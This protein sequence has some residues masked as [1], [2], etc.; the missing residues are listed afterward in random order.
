MAL[1]TLKYDENGMPKRAKYRIVVLGNLA[2]YVWLKSD[3][4]A[5]VMMQLELQLLLSQVV[6]DKCIL[7]SLD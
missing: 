1:A 6:D 7:K 3:C 2:P 4:F 5:P